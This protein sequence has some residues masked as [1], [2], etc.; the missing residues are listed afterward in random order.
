MGHTIYP[1]RQIIYRRLNDLK[2]FASCLRDPYRSRLLQLI[3]SVYLNISAIVYANSF[4]DEEMIIYT[5]L[6]PLACAHKLEH[7]DKVV[8][9]LAILLSE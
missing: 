9:C 6:V 2:R 4:D 8:R 3:D 7:A 1:K 5:M